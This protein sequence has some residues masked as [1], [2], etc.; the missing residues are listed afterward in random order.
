MAEPPA[1]SDSILLINEQRQQCKSALR[2]V[3]LQGLFM[4]KAV[5]RNISFSKSI[6]DLVAE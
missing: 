1:K 5:Y 3:F 2:L 4:I 6:S